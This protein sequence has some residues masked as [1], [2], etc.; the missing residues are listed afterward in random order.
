[1]TPDLPTRVREAFDA[2]YARQTPARGPVMED[3]HHEATAAALAAV[4][5][6]V[7]ED[8]TREIEEWCGTGDVAVRAVGR[9]IGERFGGANPCTGRNER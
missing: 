7:Q 1:M 3:V 5:A 9:A 2:E 6:V 8:R 4:I